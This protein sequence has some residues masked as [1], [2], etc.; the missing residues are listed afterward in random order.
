M[1]LRET[2]QLAIASKGIA[3][4]LVRQIAMFCAR[5][6]ERNSMGG[7]AMLSLDAAPPPPA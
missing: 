3:T 2:T 1:A 5:F 7:A 4:T 6:G